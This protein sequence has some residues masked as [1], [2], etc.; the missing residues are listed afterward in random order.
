[1]AGGTIR[2]RDLSNGT[3]DRL[4]DHALRDGFPVAPVETAQVT[5]SALIARALGGEPAAFA[6]LVLRYQDRLYN[7]LFRVLGS[8]EDA[9]DAVQ[10]AFVQAFVKLDTFRGS[11]AFYTWLYRIAF[12]Q[13]MSHAR[14]QRP[15]RSLDDDRADCGRDVADRQPP[16][17][18][19]LD[20][21]ERAT[22]VQRALAELSAEFRTVVVLREMD[23]C[24][25]EE[26]AEILELPVGT[27]RSR[28][29]RAR[30][31]LRDRL[32]PLV[33]ESMNEPSL[34]HG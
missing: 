8:A 23:G 7:S 27:V 15:T 32:A 26:I 30:L 14:R 13:A 2:G 29:F 18:A 1:V 22:Q 5:D 19:R 20:L 9:R 12:N 33:N 16:P 24:K 3:E 6:E 25:Y 10:D 4:S 28:L 17:D 31:E 21:S 11:S 34:K